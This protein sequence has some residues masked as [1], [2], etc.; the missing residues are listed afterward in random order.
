MCRGR[1]RP[2]PESCQEVLGEGQLGFPSAP[3]V[4]QFQP[5]LD[6]RGRGLVGGTHTAHPPHSLRNPGV[7]VVLSRVTMGH[8]HFGEDTS[9]PGLAPDPELP[10]APHKGASTQREGGFAAQGESPGS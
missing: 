4:P 2:T 1:G 3:G 5:D 9:A 8:S 7:A 6:L 10:R